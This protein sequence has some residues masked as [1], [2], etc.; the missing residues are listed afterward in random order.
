MIRFY[1]DLLAARDEASVQLQWSKEEFPIVTRLSSI[2]GKNIGLRHPH[3]IPDDPIDVVFW[4]YQ[5]GIDGRNAMSGI[6]SIFRFKFSPENLA[7]L[8]GGNLRDV[9][10]FINENKGDDGL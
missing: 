6:E 1:E 5:D 3:F 9:V 7:R 2:I 10:A 4:P 8:S